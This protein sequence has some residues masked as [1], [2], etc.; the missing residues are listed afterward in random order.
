MSKEL[1]VTPSARA[2]ITTGCYNAAVPGCVQHLEA[3][4]WLLK[5]GQA[6]R[7]ELHALVHFSP[8][9]ASTIKESSQRT[10]LGW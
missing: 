10:V 6:C 2:A 5:T 7:C 9:A 4:T 8:A 3:A 1:S